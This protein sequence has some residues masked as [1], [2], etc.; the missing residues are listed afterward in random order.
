LYHP[1]KNIMALHFTFFRQSSIH[2][3]LRPAWPGKG[4]KVDKDG[5]G[6]ASIFDNVAAHHLPASSW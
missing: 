5:L 4:A 6:S 1:L 2:A 3:G